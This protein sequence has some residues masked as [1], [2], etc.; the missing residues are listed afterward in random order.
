MSE[1]GRGVADANGDS[2]G[3]PAGQVLLEVRL[4]P[5]LSLDQD[6]FRIL[7]TVFTLAGLTATQLRNAQASQSVFPLRPA[8]QPFSQ[9]TL[10]KSPRS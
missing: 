5:H 8:P 7:M 2:V 1:R 10:S 6:G 9:S 4:V 3:A